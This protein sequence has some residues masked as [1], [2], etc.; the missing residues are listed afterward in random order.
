MNWSFLENVLGETVPACIKKIL[1]TCGYNTIASLR[2]INENSVLK[3]EEFINESGCEVIKTLDC[4]FAEVYQKQ[5]IFKLL[6]GHNALLLEFPKYLSSQQQHV[7]CAMPKKNYSLILNKLIETAENNANK[8]K[9]NYKYDDI[10]RYFAT[11]VYILC[12]KYCYE[13]LCHNL[14]L[15]STKT[16]CK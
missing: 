4:C 9:N 2:N 1:Y 12:G 16:V 6:P 3:I 10:I 8:D 5:N 7:S 11:Y 14:P 13:F 15:P